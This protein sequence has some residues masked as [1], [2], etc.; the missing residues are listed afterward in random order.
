MV[1]MQQ[2]LPLV[3]ITMQYVLT[4]STDNFIGPVV[5]TNEA[6][7]LDDVLIDQD[8]NVAVSQDYQQTMTVMLLH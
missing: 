1:V 2:H 3:E 7:G 6:T 4:T 5:Q 8:N